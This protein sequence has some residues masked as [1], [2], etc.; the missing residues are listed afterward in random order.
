[1][2]C[3]QCTPYLDMH[4]SFSTAL[5][6]SHTILCIKAATGVYT[7]YVHIYGLVHKELQF[8]ADLKAFTCPIIPLTEINTLVYMASMKCLCDTLCTIKSQFAS[9]F[10]RAEV[11]PSCW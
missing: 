2:R 7:V 5:P 9:F 3:A 4:F 10:K 11:A 8:T 1:M 6:P